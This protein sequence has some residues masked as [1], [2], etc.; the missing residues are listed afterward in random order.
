MRMGGTSFPC[1]HM[2][3]ILRDCQ[4]RDYRF[5]Y[6]SGNN[7][8]GLGL[9]ICV[10][11]SY[12]FLDLC[13]GPPSFLSCPSYVYFYPQYSFCTWTL[14]LSF[15]SFLC[16]CFVG[17]LSV[18]VSL[19]VS[20]QLQA[21]SLEIDV[22]AHS[23]L[24]HLILGGKELAVDLDAMRQRNISHIIVAAKEAPTPFPGES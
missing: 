24:D 5:R 16:P 20:P 10:Y 23:I 1:C 22:N 4:S 11:V 6:H 3:F 19:S 17:Y 13:S 8:N 9:S 14:T 12:L 15:L 7:N 21:P 18:S 2:V